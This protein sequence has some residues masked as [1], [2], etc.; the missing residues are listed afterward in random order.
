[1]VAM[2]AVAGGGP[3]PSNC[4]SRGIAPTHTMFMLSVWYIVSGE[5]YNRNQIPPNCL[6]HYS[7]VVAAYGKVAPFKAL[8]VVSQPARRNWYHLCAGFLRSVTVVVP[9]ALDCRYVAAWPFS[10]KSPRSAQ[11]L[12]PTDTSAPATNAF[13]HNN[14]IR[15]SQISI[16]LLLQAMVAFPGRCRGLSGI[17][18]RGSAGISR[19][20]AALQRSTIARTVP[21]ASGVKREESP[22]TLLHS[23]GVCRKSAASLPTPVG[24]SRLPARPARRSTPRRA[25]PAV[26]CI[27]SEAFASRHVWRIAR[28]RTPRQPVSVRERLQFHEQTGRCIFIPTC[29]R[30]D[31]RIPADSLRIPSA[32]SI[33]TIAKGL[34]AKAAIEDGIARGADLPPVMGERR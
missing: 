22:A 31:C 24:N 14:A 33:T 6:D 16:T 23:V 28:V 4:V 20:D 27:V 1:M 15:V 9:A 7:I 18:P 34:S 10:T 5:R 21:V 13:N 8:V 32:R 29:R 25:Q 2:P 19:R 11:R 30:A 26:L 17:G 3:W 12:R